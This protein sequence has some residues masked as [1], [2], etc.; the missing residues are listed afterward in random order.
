MKNENKF[1]TKKENFRNNKQKIVWL[2]EN[3]QKIINTFPKIRR[4]KK[5]ENVNN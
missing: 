3:L 2:N 5:I 1:K 4:K